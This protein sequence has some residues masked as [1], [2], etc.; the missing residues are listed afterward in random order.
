MI[1]PKKTFG[2]QQ[3]GGRGVTVQG[4]DYLQCEY[5]Q[6]LVFTTDNPLSVDRVT[7]SG[8]QLAAECPVCPKT[9]CTGQIEE[10]PVLYCGGCYGLLLKNEDFGAITRTRRAR[11]VGGEAEACRPLNMD[12]YDRR[13]RCPNCRERMEVH[14]Y[15]GPGNIVMDSCP[16]CQ[17]VWLDHGELR[18]V[19]QAEGGRAPEPM[20]LHDNGEV[21]IIPAP[22]QGLS[23]GHNQQDSPLQSIADLLFGL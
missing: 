5:C 3:C 12:E 14:P 6:A 15:Y 8:G 16:G 18:T 21:T 20:P 9:L 17:Y 1:A 10:R 23:S 13:I 7:P 11:R 2:C 22:L 4:R 19:E